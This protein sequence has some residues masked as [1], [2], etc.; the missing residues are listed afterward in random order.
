[1]LFICSSSAQNPGDYDLDCV[2]NVGENHVH[3]IWYNDPDGDCLTT[4]WYLNITDT[5]SGRVFEAWSYQ[6]DPPIEWDLRH[7]PQCCP[8][9]SNGTGG[10]QDPGLMC[11]EILL[12]CTSMALATED[13]D[14]FWDCIGSC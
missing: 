7:H 11:I 5:V 2:Y 6:E 13:W 3:H 10:T 8:W 9:G 14:A 4:D 12:N 1:M